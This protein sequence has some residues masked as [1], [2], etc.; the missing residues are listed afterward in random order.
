MSSGILEVHGT[1]S[2]AGA[3][4]IAGLTATLRDGFDFSVAAFEQGGDWNDPLPDSLVAQVAHVVTI[5]MPLDELLRGYTAGNAVIS[6]FVAREC[7]G[8]PPEALTYSIEVQSRV[9]DALIGGLSAEYARQSALLQRSETGRVSGE[10]ER[11]LAGEPFADEVIRYRLDGWHL[12]G[13]VAGVRAEQAIRV[14]AERLGCEL[15]VV[16]RGA[17]TFWAWWGGRR[18]IAFETAEKVVEDVR[19]RSWFALG[20]CR[21]GRDGFCGSHREARLAAD[22]AVRSGDARVVRGSGAILVA[23]L[24]RDRDAAH[25]FVDSH[26]GALKELK[27]WPVMRATLEAYFEAGGTLGGAAAALGVDRHTIRRRLKRIEEAM[28]RSLSSAWAETEVALRVDRLMADDSHIA[29]P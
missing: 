10:V 8:L 28:G 3:E 26:L 4:L 20:E 2:G 16:P 14:V 19:G 27:D 1:R 11:L 23:V 15:L 6:R 18:R 21:E 7:R 17:E 22:V 24:L 13:V 5:G 29:W 12:A 25:L 9:A